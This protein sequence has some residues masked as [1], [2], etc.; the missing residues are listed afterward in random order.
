MNYQQH[1]TFGAYPVWQQ[2]VKPGDT[3]VDAT[4]FLQEERD[5]LYPY[6]ASC[7]A[8]LA[9]ADGNLFVFASKVRLN[10]EKHV[11]V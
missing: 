9:G 1:F 6:H 3:V 11:H 10:F 8:T 4:F 2:I 7:L 5:G